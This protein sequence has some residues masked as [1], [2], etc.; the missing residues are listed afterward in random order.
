MH[1]LKS[2][3]PDDFAACFYQKAWDTVRSEVCIAILDFLNGG[4]FHKKINKTF[5]ALIPKIKNPTHVSELRPISLCN[6]I[7]KLIAKVLVN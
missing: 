4:I 7:Y 2:P 1:P 3:G 5:I 6:V